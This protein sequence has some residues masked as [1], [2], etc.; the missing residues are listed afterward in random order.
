MAHARRAPHLV[1]DVADLQ[2]AAALASQAAD[3][4]QLVDIGLACHV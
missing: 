2:L 3:T 4:L 1:H